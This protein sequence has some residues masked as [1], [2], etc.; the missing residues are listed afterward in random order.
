MH[1]WNLVPS[2]A[3]AVVRLFSLSF[4]SSSGNMV[5][6]PRENPP[7]LINSSKAS[8]PFCAYQCMSPPYAPITERIEVTDGLNPNPTIM[9]LDGVTLGVPALVFGQSA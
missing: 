8:L 3:A 5:N 6:N 1:L 2:S 4:H 9:A 7:S